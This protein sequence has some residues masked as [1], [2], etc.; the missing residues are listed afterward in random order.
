VNLNVSLEAPRPIRRK[1]APQPVGVSSP[2]SMPISPFLFPE[3]GTALEQIEGLGVE[4]SLAASEYLYRQGDLSTAMYYTLSGRVRIF[5][6]RP[7][8][9]ER[10]LAFAGPRTTFGEFGVF[11]NLPCP[12]SAVAVRPSRVLVID[13]AAF[14]AAGTVAPEIFFEVGRRLAQ[15]TR[16]L[17]LHIATDGLPVSVRVA[18]VLTHLM[19][20]YGVVKPDNTAR[21]T[22]WHR[23]DDLAQLI[24]VTRVSVSRELS[25]LVAKKVV[26][27][28][29]REIVIL[30]MAALQ[31]VAKDYFL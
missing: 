7:D 24:G 19:N 9:S 25:R 10:I 16:L 28:G 3:V 5:I 4:R 30:N 15:K 17:S 23:V 26:V 29:K 18:M 1:T 14:I 8:G 13:R 11:D 2:R 27:K 6:S 31:A 21:L 20:A 22:E 12:T